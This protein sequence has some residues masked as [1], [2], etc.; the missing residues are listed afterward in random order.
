MSS[1]R[2]EQHLRG[3][4]ILV[5]TTVGLCDRWLRSSSGPRLSKPGQRGAARRGVWRGA[6]RRGVWRGVAWRGVAWRR[7]WRGVRGVA[8]RGVAWRG[9]A[10]RACLPLL[11]FGRARQSGY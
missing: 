5:T 1:D 7:G 3:A 9:A 4:I 10:Q 8:W 2:P 11:L 6:A